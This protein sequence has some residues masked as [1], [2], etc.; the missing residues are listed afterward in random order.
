LSIAASCAEGKTT[1]KDAK[2]L[3]VKESDR[4]EAIASGLKALNVPSLFV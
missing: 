2:E 4:L 1:I 3:R